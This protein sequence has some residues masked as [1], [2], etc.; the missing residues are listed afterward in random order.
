V[1]GIDAADRSSLGNQVV[2][3]FGHVFNAEPALCFPLIGHA[4]NHLNEVN[5]GQQL[6]DAGVADLCGV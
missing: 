3:G 5:E 2:D 6:V 1:I 4:G